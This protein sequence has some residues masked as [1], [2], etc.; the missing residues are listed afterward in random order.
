MH[1]PC[2]LISLR[3]ASWVVRATPV[4]A[5][6]RMKRI[7]TN[8]T[9]RGRTGRTGEIGIGIERRVFAMVGLGNGV[10]SPATGGGDATGTIP[11]PIPILLRFTVSR[12][13]SAIQRTTAG[14]TPPGLVGIL[15]ALSRGR[16]APRASVVE[17]LRGWNG[18]LRGWNGSRR[19]GW[20]RPA[21]QPVRGRCQDAPHEAPLENRF[22]GRRHWDTV[23]SAPTDGW[24]VRRRHGPSSVGCR[25]S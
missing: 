6:P 1:H 2:L 3:F 5:E 25:A 15:R 13:Q 17:P 10:S 18:S 9:G 20:I 8:G 7:V 22:Q 19:P 21:I 11:V 4:I 23:V 16:F 24:V 14:S 12:L